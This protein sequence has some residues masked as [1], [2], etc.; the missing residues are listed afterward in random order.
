M[1]DCVV[2]GAGPAG[3]AASVALTARGIDHLVLER[4]RA[5]QTWRTQRWDSLRLN[6][7]GW[8]NRMLG[9]QPPNTYLTAVEVVERLD[10]LA[11]LAP[12]REH[13]PVLAMSPHHTGWALHTGV[14][15]IRTRTVIVATG[16]EN[17]PR[18]PPLA[19]RLPANIAQLHAATYRRPAQLP[20]GAVLVVGSA[21]SG[22]QITE[23]LLRAG[24]RVILATSRVGRAPARHRGRDTIDLLG[25]CGFFDQRP[26][27]VPDPAV[28]H[29]PQPL[30]A[31]GGRSASLQT[32]ARNGASLTGRLVSVD[33]Q[34]LRFDDSL[35]A[36]IA[37]ADA[38]AARIRALLDELTYPG[39]PA[40]PVE[41]DLADLPIEPDPPTTMHLGRAGIGSVIWCTGY[42]G[43]FSWL[44]TALVDEA[45]RPIR[46]GAAGALPGVWYL[47][48]RWLIR[49]SSGNFLGFPAD[50]TAVA[51]AIARTL[52]GRP[53][54]T[55]RGDHRMASR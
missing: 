48:L 53:R 9:D 38:F 31:P 37:A 40:P 49:R 41:P 32:L 28:I 46:H 45:G 20:A 33:G 50:A 43:D 29:G 15:Q 6:N 26:E 11:A 17:V 13:S 3:L 52:R 35:A 36:N 51:D 34:H 24:R 19:R 22:Y 7:P 14:G 1:T 16:G 54:R 18:T 4:A 23:D 39:R 27:D 8:M 47:G 10:R 5:G 12:V 21:Q 25:A 44:D 42:T 55:A 30:L 2:V